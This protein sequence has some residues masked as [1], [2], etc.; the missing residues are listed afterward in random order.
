MRRYPFFLL[1][2]ASCGSDQSF[3]YDLDPIE[4]ARAPITPGGAATG[5]LLANV[6]TSAGIQPL[7][8]DSAYPINS[9]APAGCAGGG[10]PG[11]TYTGNVD[12]RDASAAAVVRASFDDIGLFDL[13]SGPTGDAATQPA[14]VMGGPLLANFSVGFVFPRSAELPATMTLWSAFP[15][16]D[17]RLE[18]N[19]FVPLHFNLRGG[20]SAGRGNGEASLALPN[21]RIVMAACAAPRV[22]STTEPLETCASGQAALKAS[23]QDLTLAIGTGEGPLILSQSAWGRIA[24][25]LGMANDAGTAGDLYTPFSTAPISA[26]FLTVPGLA[27]FQGTTDTGW[28]GPCTE[29]ARARRI[30]W[31]LANQDAGAC[32]QPCD[33]SSGK[34]IATHPYLEL[35]GPLDLAVI[36]ETSDLIQSLNA[37]T[38]PNPQVDGIIGAGT[39]AGTRTRLDYT[40]QP[41]GR[42][43]ATCEDGS[44]RDQCWTAPSCWAT[45]GPHICFGQPRGQSGW[46]PVCP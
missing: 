30:E 41:Q 1:L 46:A 4:L 39:L 14:G 32:F 12:L 38:P 31:V 35:G 5:G 43:V 24:A 16:S 45:G 25:Q 7:L 40:S 42:V 33:A 36:S 18:Q 28:S 26:H 8:V 3:V 17:D 27:V 2:L 15:G 29:L 20:A 23:G 19:G 37:D 11:W 34:A 44:T 22:F 6:S 9:L 13:C 21:S 10:T